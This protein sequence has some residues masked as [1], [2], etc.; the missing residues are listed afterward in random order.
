NRP[1]QTAL[2]KIQDPD[3]GVWHRMGDVGYFDAQG[4]LWFCGRKAHRVTT[5]DGTLFP[6]PCETIFNAHP[7]VQRTALV[8]VG[9]QGHQ[10]PVLIVEPRKGR[11]PQSI[12]EK[13]RFTLELLALGVEYPHTRDIQDVLFYPDIF[14]TDVRHNVKIQREKLATWAV[15]HYHESLHTR[16]P[17]QHPDTRPPVSVRIGDLFRALSILLSVAVSILFLRRYLKG[18]EPEVGSKEYEVG[19]KE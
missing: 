14:P 1:Q 9:P 17:V 12:L 5:P 3:G 11:F 16:P 8:G 15:K 2:A 4:R 19:S 6:V 13:Q 10:R 18:K 7:N